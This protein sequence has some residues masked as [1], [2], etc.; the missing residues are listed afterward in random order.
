[1]DIEDFSS[2]SLQQIKRTWENYHQD[3]STIHHLDG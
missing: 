2:N 1:M 3:I